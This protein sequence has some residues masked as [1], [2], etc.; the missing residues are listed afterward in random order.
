MR[1][2]W[3]DAVVIIVGVAC[4][5]GGALLALVE[6]TVGGLIATIGF[7]III[8]GYLTR[9]MA[10]P[11]N[12]RGPGGVAIEGNLDTLPKVVK[13]PGRPDADEDILELEF[14]RS[15]GSVSSET[16]EYDWLKGLA[17]NTLDL[18][19]SGEARDRLLAIQKRTGQPEEALVS[20]GL[21]LLTLAV[22]DDDL[23]LRDRDTSATTLIKII[24]PS[25]DVTERGGSRIADD[26]N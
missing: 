4:L 25:S 19:I 6:P 3:V 24:K 13:K 14:N 23:M 18:S 21:V 16:L 20:L 2:G 10:G 9:R 22:S 15:A 26:H 12:I 1:R 5:P 8:L 17:P 7:V 11:I